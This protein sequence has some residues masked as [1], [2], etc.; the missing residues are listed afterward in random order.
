MGL[1]R[2]GVAGLKGIAVLL[3]AILAIAGSMPM[4]QA[5]TQ[6]V[7][8][9][10]LERDLRPE[11]S[12][13]LPTVTSARMLKFT[14]P[15]N[16]TLS[17]KSTVHVDF[18]HA[19]QLLPQRSFLQ[20]LVNDKVIHQVSLGPN[21]TIGTS[22]N[23]PLPIGIL[24]DFNQLWFRV[25]QHYT[26]KCEDPADP[27]LW[28]QVLPSSYILFDY[29]TTLPKLD[30][31]FFPYPLLDVKAYAP[32]RIRYI[33]PKDAAVKSVH[34]L[35]MMN[36]FLAQAAE[37]SERGQGIT[38][39]FSFL[40][41]RIP[42]VEGEHWVYV[43]TGKQLANL[44]FLQS[45]APYKLSNG[46]WMDKGGQA[47]SNGSGVSL[48][49]RNAAHPDQAILI[50]SGNDAEGV[51]QAARLV[52]TRPMAEGMNGTAIQ[53]D[54]SWTPNHNRLGS[55]PH[56]IEDKNVT[57]ADLGFAT[58]PV[59]RM[60]APPI[61]YDVPVV[62]DF[63]K[64]NAK[65][66]LDLVYSY[67]AQNGESA[68]NPRYS[69]LELRWN[70]ISVAN[71]PLLNIE[72]EERQ[73]ATVEIPPELIRVKNKLVAQFHLMPDKY[74][75]CVDD[76]DDTSWGKI[77]DDSRFRI[78]GSVASRLPDV[79][80]LNDGVGYPYTR[81]GNLADVHVM[82]PQKPDAA[83]M[84]TLM[85]VTNRL[86]M[87]SQSDT[88]LRFTMGVIGDSLPGNKDVLVIAKGQGP[89]D[90]GKGFS[91]R[92]PE[93]LKE[94][95]QKFFRLVGEKKDSRFADGS[96]LGG[97]LEQ[98]LSPGNKKRV[99]TLLS[100]HDAEAQAALADLFRDDDRFATLVVESPVAQV[101][102]L[103]PV[104]ASVATPAIVQE[105]APPG[106]WYKRIPWL[107]IIVGIVVGLFLLIILLPIVI[108][109]FR[110]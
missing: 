92:W 58:Q 98:V 95:F 96:T 36:V 31:K 89:D 68:L 101:S 25:V 61:Q 54:S 11:D 43:G 75:F 56:F 38:P 99:V 39:T 51:L 86:G 84:R 94:P 2:H 72:G 22:F 15:D 100:G 20:V 32:S 52:T 42:A 5:L 85:S 63:K 53:A 57:F 102:P 12:I 3:L 74:G 45:A 79:G 97:Y 91:L 21:N 28:T 50:L 107:G 13:Y 10:A 41:D 106:P 6:Q 19:L 30:F 62:T 110:R 93:A 88:D 65:L 109:L 55:K 34:A 60:T 87:L 78:Q 1:N 73:T 7:S 105:S 9:N 17:G 71:I 83:V 18:Q 14:K 69:S 29:T 16:W 48:L 67:G 23:V 47:I 44:S 76:F 35:A 81:K 64:N 66:L 8:V 103:N 26:D 37:S 70:N 40:G 90:V 104:T 82:V 49:F 77:H 80:L 108:R 27:S 4:A 59:E 33:L 46:V 24:K